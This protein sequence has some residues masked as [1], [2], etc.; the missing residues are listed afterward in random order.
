M[1]GR[2]WTFGL[3]RS[4]VA[5]AVTMMV[6]SGAGAADDVNA[7]AKAIFEATGVR[8]GLVVHLGCGE[9]KLTAAL[10]AGERYVVH[11][12][13]VD[14]GDVERARTHV[15]SQGLYGP[16]SIA[17]L[18]T[19]RLPY[20]ENLV[21]LLVADEGLDTVTQ[22]EVLRVLSPEGVAYVRSGGRWVKTVKPRPAAIDEWTHWLHG[23]DG[24]AV[25][26]DRTVGPPRRMQWQGGPLWSRHHNLMP[27]VSAMVSS[28]G[29]LFTIVDDAPPA[30]TGDS[31]DRWALVARDAFNGIELWRRPIDDWGWR[32]WSWRWEGRFNQ[33]NQIAKRLVA[34]GD[35]V[36]V[37]LGFN[38]PLTALDAATGKVVKTYE[39]TQFTDEILYQDGV[40]ILSV[41]H[42]AQ[43]AA[44]VPIDPATG[45]EAPVTVE[46]D[47]P[48]TKSVTAIEAKTGKVLWKT[49]RFVGNS[50][51]TSGL[52]RVTHLL[53]AAKGSRVYLLDRTHVIALDLK[54][55]KKLWQAPR[56]DSKR[57]TSRYYHLMS[58]MCTLVATDKAILLCQLE[59]I[60]KRIG[61]RVI[62]ARMRAYDPKTGAEMWTE[63][64]GNWG[65]FC[66]PDVFVTG[67]LAWVHDSEAMACIGLDLT[68]GAEKRRV[69]T[70]RAFDN[71]H[72]HRCHRN[73]ATDRFLMTSFRGYEFTD[74]ATGKT[75]LNHW[76]RGMCRLGG[77]PCNGL[78]YSTPHPCDCYISVLV[79]G[80]V[81]LAPASETKSKIAAAPR[82]ERGPAFGRVNPQSAIR[83]PQSSW[84]TYRH[85]AARSGGTTATLP[86][87]L[88]LRWTGK[89]AGRLS[90]PVVA[91]GRVV[92]ASVD[93]HGVHAL[94]AK[95][96][97]TLWSYTAGG[98]VDTPPTLYKGMALFGCSDGAVYCLRADDGKLVW[99][100]RA[101]PHERL[102]GAF[103]RLQSAWPV[104][105]SVLVQNDR[106]YVTAGRSSF[107]DGGMT[108]WCLDPAT[109]AVLQSTPI[110]SEQDAIVDKGRDP[111]TDYGLAAD[112]MTGDGRGVYM[113]QR[114][115][116]S[117]EG[118]KGGWSGRLA[119]TGGMLSDEW[120]NRT[121]WILDGTLQ[122][123]TL[124]HDA[125]TVYAVRAYKQRGHGGFVKAGEAK[126]LLAAT[127]RKPVATDPEKAA[128]RR[129]GTWKPPARDKWTRPVSPRVRALAL[130]GKTL[131]CTGTPDVL[132]P[133]DPWAAYEG[134]RGGILLTVSTE[135]GKTLTNLTFDGGPVTDGI[136]IANG[137]IYV[138][139]NDGRVLCFGGK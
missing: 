38:A 107:L 7:R 43:R 53:L 15:T 86:A 98:Q 130:A 88:A 74:W 20:A 47:P 22:A 64:C 25:A 66:V 99:R 114:R 110:I 100:F 128:K 34:I 134:K 12:L 111:Q 55:G 42:A 61:W 136:A 118:G 31:P 75:D 79:K 123:E 90:A 62:K 121:Y 65:H 30:M 28:G 71:G 10:R 63:K 120:F 16:V 9:G 44:K 69:S 116:F 80:M 39:G 2:T 127:S 4:L 45:R 108:A 95:T 112:L 84:P 101:A 14:Q 41:N 113:R 105:G 48:V 52:E 89:L 24:N 50:T 27:S 96:G 92:V 97:R 29:R 137:C 115:L 56:P 57:Y 78:L 132:D 1:A 26:H 76:V 46:D 67:G 104:H 36:Y 8:G 126:Y 18:R 5:V 11:G 139:T 58:D 70:E 19:T 119:A 103:S 17:R 21:N 73:K 85:D 93:T 81:A 37:T 109:G 83:N 129:E 32:A 33:P 106:A 6:A 59:P 102:V 124:V 54:S 131:V 122:G 82:L 35:R 87:K 133:K 13:D 3:T 94:D 135:D 60:Q 23:P 72:H 138:T 49:G 117:P 51:K 68:T 77:M 125:S 40:L 91:G